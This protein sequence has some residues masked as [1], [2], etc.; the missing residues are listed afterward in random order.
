MPVGSIHLHKRVLTLYTQLAY[1]IRIR[2]LSAIEF[3]GQG[4]RID[5]ARVNDRTTSFPEKN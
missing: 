3:L 2:V 5:A 1:F 4:P